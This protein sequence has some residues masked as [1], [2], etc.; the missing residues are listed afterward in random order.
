MIVMTIFNRNI[1][2]PFYSSSQ[3][4]SGHGKFDANE[5]KKARAQKKSKRKKHK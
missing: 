2:V 1:K 4:F 5:V 3:R